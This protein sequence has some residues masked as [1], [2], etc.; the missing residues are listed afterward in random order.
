MPGRDRRGRSRSIS[1]TAHGC[2]EIG[3]GGLLDTSGCG[4]RHRR[5]R[6]ARRG[7]RPTSRTDGEDA[8]QGKGGTSGEVQG[9]DATQAERLPTFTGWP[10][11]GR[12]IG[13]RGRVAL[14]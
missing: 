11:V 12:E 6:S 4:T 9:E 13:T 7:K 5:H 1:R 8:P 10:D 2:R 14:P 3:R